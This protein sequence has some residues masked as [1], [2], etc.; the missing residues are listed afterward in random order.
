MTTYH[1]EQY[2]LSQADAIQLHHLSRAREA[3]FM[4]MLCLDA[5]TK[6]PHNLDIITQQETVESHVT[7]VVMQLPASEEH[8][9][10]Y[11]STQMQDPLCSRV[12]D[13]TK[14]GWMNKQ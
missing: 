7:T 13:F 5:P 3:T 2:A 1:C 14:T 12:I 4:L 9:K 6:L 11:R 10:V 8:L